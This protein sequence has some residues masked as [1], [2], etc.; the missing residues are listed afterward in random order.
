MFELGL[1]NA[2]TDMGV[3]ERLS[4]NLAA[5]EDAVYHHDQKVVESTAGYRII[6]FKISSTGKI[7]V[8]IL[9]VPLYNLVLN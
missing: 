2:E 7:E 3:S 1:K 5:N 9:S 8:S 6:P 4:Q